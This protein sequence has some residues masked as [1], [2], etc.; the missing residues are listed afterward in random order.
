MEILKIKVFT[1]NELI[2]FAIASCWILS[3]SNFVKPSFFV[4]CFIIL[5]WTRTSFFKKIEILSPLLFWNCGFFLVQHI[6]FY[7]F[8]AGNIAVCV[9]LVRV[10][11]CLAGNIAVCFWLVRV[12][13]CL[14]WNIAVCFWLVR[15]NSC[16]AW[17]IAI[18]FWFVKENS[19]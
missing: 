14:S 7:D 5:S 13:S 11:S 3:R 18:C 10:N 4:R 19:C 12:N 9:W 16:L 17:N 15:V 8:F 1:V 2:T 6:K